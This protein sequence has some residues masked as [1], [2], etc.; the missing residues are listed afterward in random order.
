[1]KLN[2]VYILGDMI[3]SEDIV[4][5]ILKSD[6]LHL[7][8]R[9]LSNILFDRKNMIIANL[10]G[11]I[12]KNNILQRKGGSPNIKSCPDIMDLFV[13][14]PNLLIS[15][16]NNHITDY[17]LIG[18]KDTENYLDI[19]HIPHIGFGSR[20]NLIDKVFSF[21][22]SETHITVCAFAQNEFSTINSMDVESAYGANPYDPL[23]VFDSIEKL[24]KKSDY[25]ICVFHGGKENYRY[26]SP[27]L[28]KIC[29]KMCEKGADL[30]VCQH[31]HCV[32]CM[33]VYAGKSII[34]GTGNF[35]FNLSD[36]SLW[37]TSILPYIEIS[38]DQSIKLQFLPIVRDGLCIR[39]ADKEEENE[40]I[41]GFLHRT[42]E[43]K[44]II[45]VREN[46]RKYC[47][48]NKYQILNGDFFRFP[49][50]IRWLDFKTNYFISKRKLMNWRQNF[51]TLN[52]IRC[53]IINE[54]SQT[55][56]QD[57]V[58][59]QNMKD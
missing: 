30:V 42:E 13:K 15:G 10:E 40:I 12:T 34:Y 29:R 49:K 39:I 41:D 43:I 4:T 28:M 19:N 56:L 23:V 57:L 3:C 16:A 14:I 22:L 47:K 8:G 6:Y 35:L 38:K 20:K 17:G 18:I 52:D 50:L 44:D 51:T 31:S 21:R 36:D 7:F 11:P 5:Y 48:E 53:E 27:G 45:F 58:K 25:I 54:M 1:M 32:G 37:L 59:E 33:E 24:K 2:K 55:I 26:P 9:E 46:W